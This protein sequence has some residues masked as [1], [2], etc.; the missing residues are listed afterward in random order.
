MF[1][2]RRARPINEAM[3]MGDTDYATPGAHTNQWAQAHQ[4]E[5]MAKNV[6]V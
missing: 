4:F 3:I 1:G 2:L 5:A 6:T